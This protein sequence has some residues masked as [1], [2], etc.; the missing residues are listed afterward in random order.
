MVHSAWVLQWMAINCS[1]RIH[2]ERE[3]VNMP[4]IVLSLKSKNETVESLC[5]VNVHYRPP[6]QVENADDEYLFLHQLQQAWHLW[7]L[8]PL[9]DISSKKPVKEHRKPPRFFNYLCDEPKKKKLQRQWKQ[10]SSIFMGP[11]MRYLTQL[12]G[13]RYNKDI[14]L[15]DCIQSRARKMVVEDWKEAE[16]DG[17]VYLREELTTGRLSAAFQFLKEIYSKHGVRLFSKACS[18]IIRE[19]GFRLK[20]D[21]RNNCFT[22]S[23]V[24]HWNWLIAQRECRCSILRNASPS[25][26]VFKAKYFGAL[27]YLI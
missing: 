25:L 19:N 10:M 24:R 3:V 17:L 8:V 14:D 21:A 20:E 5:M 15:P 2:E 22:T 1:E 11:H 6:G 27:G 13:T 9:G 12:W 16:R 26:E 4:C 23:M 7:T 18:D